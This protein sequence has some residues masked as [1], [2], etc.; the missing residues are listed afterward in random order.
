MVVVEGW[1]WRK[2]IQKG[3]N[4][5][6]KPKQRGLTPYLL[7]YSINEACRQGPIHISR[8]RMAQAAIL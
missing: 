6:F 5:L 4:G 3:I 2:Q 7:A 8:S 1:M